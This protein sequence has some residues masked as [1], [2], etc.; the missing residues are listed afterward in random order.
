MMTVM[1]MSCK[2]GQVSI[3]HG[4]LDVI[5]CMDTVIWHKCC[6]FLVLEAV[7]QQSCNVPAVSLF[8]FTHLVIM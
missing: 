5:R 3:L 8:A 1:L 2:A 4:Y 7:L 6:H